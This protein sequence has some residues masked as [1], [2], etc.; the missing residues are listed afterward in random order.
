MQLGFQEL[1]AATVFQQFH[2]VPSI[3]LYHL[4]LIFYQEPQVISKIKD[5]IIVVTYKIL[6]ML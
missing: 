4:Q 5:I 3:F 2:A 6:S 1:I